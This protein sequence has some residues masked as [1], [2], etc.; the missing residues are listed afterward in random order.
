MARRSLAF[1]PSS[2]MRRAIAAVGLIAAL[3]MLLSGCGRTSAP[4]PEAL[5]APHDDAAWVAPVAL[6]A[7]SGGIASPM[8]LCTS[9]DCGPDAAALHWS[10]G[11][12]GHTTTGYYVYVKSTALGQQVA[13]VHSSPW[14]IPGGGCG[15]TVLLGVRAHDNA[16][17][18]PDTSPLYSFSY[19]T[20]A[21]GGGGGGGAYAGNSARWGPARDR[22]G[23]DVRR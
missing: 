22:L 7:P 8:P 13:D 2:R 10:I 23:A 21:C 11:P 15:T 9:N 16:T 5:V 1:V 18:T 6:H 12:W 20:P 19:R 17:P 3:A 4:Q 14:V